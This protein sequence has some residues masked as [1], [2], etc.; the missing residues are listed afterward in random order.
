MT[1]KYAVTALDKYIRANHRLDVIM[2]ILSVNSQLCPRD[3]ATVLTE[4]S[5]AEYEA[6]ITGLHYT[7]QKHSPGTKHTKFPLF[8]NNEWTD[9]VSPHWTQRIPAGKTDFSEYDIFNE[10]VAPNK[11]KKVFAE[12]AVSIFSPTLRWLHPETAAAVVLRQLAAAIL[13]VEVGEVE[14]INSFLDEFT[15]LQ[16][17]ASPTYQTAFSSRTL[18]ICRIIGETKVKDKGKS[19]ELFKL[20]FAGLIEL[21]VAAR[22]WGDHNGCLTT[23]LISYNS[24]V[25][26]GAPL[27]FHCKENLPAQFDE[28]TTFR[29]NSLFCNFSKIHQICVVCDTDC[30]TLNGLLNHHSACT[31]L[32]NYACCGLTFSTHLE[33]VAHAVSFCRAPPPS[34]HPACYFCTRTPDKCICKRNTAKL[35]SLADKIIREQIGRF[36]CINNDRFSWFYDSAVRFVLFQN[37]SSG[38]AGECEE[39]TLVHLA[40]PTG[41]DYQA[42]T[43]VDEDKV[44]WDTVKTYFP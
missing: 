9:V 21:L 20:Q 16:Q 1:S 15:G 28:K 30:Q 10:N 2:S 33:A 3:E 23:P 36:D 42:R 43:G 32:K 4:Q 26:A 12:N 24:L 40:V 38:T 18:D 37:P 7:K 11:F 17:Y 6:W 44:D 29:R 31:G 14:L 8:H 34:P 22:G 25:R 35:V 5:D 19:I 41:Q 27:Y 13:G 39:Q